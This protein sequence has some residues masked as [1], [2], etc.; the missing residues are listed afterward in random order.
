[1][2]ECVMLDRVA[3][4]EMILT[5]LLAMMGVDYKPGEVNE[6]GSAPGSGQ[7]RKGKQRPTTLDRD[8]PEQMKRAQQNDARM[9]TAMRAG[10]FRLDI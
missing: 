1:M 3:T 8:D 7:G 5:P 10:G 2:A 4:M 6:S 9:L